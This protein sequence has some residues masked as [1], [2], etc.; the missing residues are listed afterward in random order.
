MYLASLSTV[1]TKNA[2]YPQSNPSA[3]LRDI[4]PCWLLVSVV[5]AVLVEPGLEAVLVGWAVGFD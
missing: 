1:V 3:L 2:R 4:P 5:E